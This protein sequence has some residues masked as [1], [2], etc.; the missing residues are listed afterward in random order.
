MEHNWKESGIGGGDEN[1]QVNVDARRANEERTIKQLLEVKSQVRDQ[2]A[3]DG[4]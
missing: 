4:E 3:R 2:V 1:I